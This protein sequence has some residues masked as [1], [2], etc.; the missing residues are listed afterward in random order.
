[1]FAGVLSLQWLERFLSFFPGLYRRITRRIRKSDAST[2]EADVRWGGPAEAELKSGVP[3]TVAPDLG[4]AAPRTRTEFPAEPSRRESWDDVMELDLRDPKALLPL[5]RSGEVPD[6]LTWLLGRPENRGDGAFG[7]RAVGTWI[8]AAGPAGAADL[9]KRLEDILADAGSSAERTSLHAELDVRRNW[10]SEDLAKIEALRD[11]GP[12]DFFSPYAGELAQIVAEKAL[13]EVR[14]VKDVLDEAS[15]DHEVPLTLRAETERLLERVASEIGSTPG[16][17]PVTEKDRLQALADA[18]ASF[19]GGRFFSIVPFLFLGGRWTLTAFLAAMVLMAVL[20]PSAE[21][22]SILEGYRLRSNHFSKDPACRAILESA[23]AQKSGSLMNWGSFEMAWG[24]EHYVFFRRDEEKKTITVLSMASMDEVRA[25]GGMTRV[26]AAL[27]ARE[28]KEP[29]Q[30]PAKERIEPPPVAAVEVVPPAEPVTADQE[31][32]EWVS[33][34]LDVWNRMKGVG[35][36]RLNELARRLGSSLPKPSRTLNL[37]KLRPSVTRSRAIDLL[38]RLKA[39]GVGD[40][41]PGTMFHEPEK[42]RITPAELGFLKERVLRAQFRFGDRSER[43]TDMVKGEKYLAEDLPAL[44]APEID[45]DQLEI[46]RQG[47]PKRKTLPEAPSP[48][49]PAPM[50]PRLS[51]KRVSPEE[52]VAALSNKTAGEAVELIPSIRERPQLIEDVVR[53]FEEGASQAQVFAGITLL[54]LQDVPPAASYLKKNFRGNIPSFPGPEGDVIKV[55]GEEFLY[56]AG[57]GEHGG[58]LVWLEAP[59]DVHVAARKNWDYVVSVKTPSAVAELV[60][61]MD[62]VLNMDGLDQNHLPAASRGAWMSRFQLR[63]VQVHPDFKK[64]GLRKVLVEEWTRRLP[65]DARIV[66]QD[67]F[68]QGVE[69]E[70]KAGVPFLETGLGRPFEEAGFNRQPVD[71]G[72]IVLFRSPSK[73]MTAQA[74]EKNAGDAVESQYHGSEKADESFLRTT[75]SWKD[76]DLR[77]DAYGAFAAVTRDGVKVP[78]KFFE[79]LPILEGEAAFLRDAMLMAHRHRAVFKAGAGPLLWQSAAPVAL[80]G[81]EEFQKQ[82]LS[83][84]RRRVDR[85]TRPDAF[86]DEPHAAVGP[87]LYDYESRQALPRG[88]CGR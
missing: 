63:G 65:R 36:G 69:K 60:F 31:E 77:M 24:S 8:S 72:R 26:A 32:D 12:H 81:A 74:P 84:R 78:I 25:R 52:I 53:V 44:M 75:K 57:I 79:S 19:V 58:F 82:W 37:L 66:I 43:L 28:N 9:L 13:R 61:D 46:V 3:P 23:L 45:P 64:T 54:A 70:M 11:R 14:S 21:T 40:G 41:A 38:N 80:V 22:E 76:N 39:L 51:T 73:E 67:M 68:D 10:L 48:D 4:S 42:P 1:M 59:A 2:D 71:D 86:P 17:K 34:R 27:A 47:L 7:V 35:A 49:V 6:F 30:P 20:G 83:P 29:P 55:G 56:K 87:G 18:V 62:G 16:N 15:L 5:A 33:S 88:N 85:G 50:E